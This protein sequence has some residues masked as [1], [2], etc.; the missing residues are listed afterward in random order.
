M[1]CTQ[2]RAMVDQAVD[3]PRSSASTVRR[4]RATLLQRM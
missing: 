4:P 2:V 1:S 3:L